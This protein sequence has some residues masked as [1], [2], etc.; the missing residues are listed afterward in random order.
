[1]RRSNAGAYLPPT[2]SCESEL[3]IAEVYVSGVFDDPLRRKTIPTLDA[4]RVAQLQ[5]RIDECRQGV[6]EIRR[7]YFEA[8]YGSN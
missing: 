6:A 2:A 1:V 8:I 5:G 3:A 4:V 7:A